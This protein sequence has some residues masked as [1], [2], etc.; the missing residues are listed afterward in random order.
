MTRASISS[1]VLTPQ[2][3]SLLWIHICLLFWITLSWMGTLF[4]VC[5]GAFRLRAADIHNLAE[6]LSAE[7]LEP[8]L[9]APHPHPPY[10]FTEVPKLDIQP[11]HQGLRCRTIMVS[12]VLPQLRDEKA[13][14]EYFEFYMSRK[15]EKPALGVNS[16]T[17]P[18][19]INKSL[20][21]LFNRAKR[22]STHFPSTSSPKNED[23]V[24]PRVSNENDSN[25]LLPRIERVTLV[26]KMTEL[27]SLLERREDILRLLETAHINLAR[28]A[29]A[30]VTAAMEMQAANK[31]MAISRSN[32]RA[33]IIAK[34]R[35][36][37]AEVEPVN[38]DDCA[39]EEERMKEL[40][41]VLRPYVDNPGSRGDQPEISRRPSTVSRR[42]FYKLGGES[43]I[44]ADDDTANYPP[45]L[46]SSSY[47]ERPTVWDAL[48]GLPRSYL[49][50]YQPLVNLSHMF[51]GKTVPAIDYYTAKLNLLTALITENRAQH[52]GGFAPVS[53][54]FVT[55]EDPADARRA[56][57]Y[58]TVHPGN[59]LA[60]MVSMA[61]QYQDLDWTR[62]MKSSYDVEVSVRWFLGFR[63]AD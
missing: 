10:G 49:D 18:G 21:F 34:Q 7:D 51:R 56:C 52:V 46:P 53:T 47:S 32:T 16:T 9:P 2:G 29:L 13:L 11:S 14:K 63:T 30:A 17:Q 54:A 41:R 25:N 40:I 22:V 27:A 39:S 58:L 15:L 20:S 4:W 37:Q 62:I 36:K 42:L 44:G 3:L 57:K 23:D 45:G 5:N 60:C 1:L 61:P 55:F 59:P 26:R 48:L 35:N 8:S 31:P 50:P 33:A 24:E 19:F 12:N 28:K 38:Q 6:R 43:T